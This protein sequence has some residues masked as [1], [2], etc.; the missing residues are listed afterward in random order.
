MHAV[1]RIHGAQERRLF[2]NG[3]CGGEANGAVEGERLVMRRSEHEAAVALTKAARRDEVEGRK[4]GLVRHDAGH[5]VRVVAVG[6]ALVGRGEGGWGL[7]QAA[8][9]LVEGKCSLQPAVVRNGLTRVDEKVAS[10]LAARSEEIALLDQVGVHEAPSVL[11]K[12]GQR[13]RSWQGICNA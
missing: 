2:D 7:R 3:A 11:E 9:L 1:L 10:K 8:S 6:V 5:K 4:V 12:D 13:V